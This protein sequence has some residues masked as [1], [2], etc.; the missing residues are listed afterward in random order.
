MSQLKVL[1]YSGIVVSLVFSGVSLVFYLGGWS[2]LMLVACFEIFV[3][4]LAV[5]EFAPR[6]S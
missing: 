6:L 4:F 5:P 1:L 2:R 3:G